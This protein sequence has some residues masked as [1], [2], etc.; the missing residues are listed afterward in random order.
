MNF[1]TADC[2]GHATASPWAQIVRP[3]TWFAM[4]SSS[5]TSVSR[6]P[7]VVMRFETRESQREPSRQGVHWPQV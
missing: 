3:A 5:G 6:P 1:G 2:T 4:S 7:P